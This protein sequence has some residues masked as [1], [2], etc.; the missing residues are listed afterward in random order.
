MD[1]EIRKLVKKA[2]KK[3]D[4]K[5]QYLIRSFYELRSVLGNDWAIFY[6]LLGGRDAGKS[7]GVTQFYVE[8][9]KNKGRPFYWIRLTDK[10]AG[11][12]LTNN[13]EK[14]IDP[15]IRRRYNLDIVTIGNRVYD[16]E[17]D[18]SGKVKKKHLMC[19]VMALSTF[20]NDKGSAYFD[21][22]FLNDPNQYYNCCLDE[23]NREIGEKN[24]FDICYAFVNQMENLFRDT[25]N[26]IRII[27]IGNTLQDASDLLCLFNFI[28]EQ[29]GRYKLKSKRAVVEYMPL[30]E[31][32]TERRKGTIADLLMGKEST[33]T[34]K[35]Q[36]DDTLVNKKRLIT[37]KYIIKFSRDD[38]RWYTVW[39]NNVIKKYNKESC[40][41]TYPMRPFIDDIYQV[42]NQKMIIDMFHLRA[43]QYHDLITFKKFQQEISILKPK[44]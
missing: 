9:F 33:F 28:P 15:D 30:T 41:I 10:S 39:D 19:T 18:S 31:K 17:R 27:M 16:V 36:V 5:Q 2:Q 26:R 37:P 8:Q 4:D 6:L 20:Y 40:K 13:A 11:A 23:M 22:D 38:N 32:Y 7:Y 42:E 35:R 43:F 1:K 21:K 29:F 25:K 3:S 34:N 44:G 24:N 12:L 14:L